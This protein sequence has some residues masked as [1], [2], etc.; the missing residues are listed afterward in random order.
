MTSRL[1][2]ILTPLE[3]KNFCETG[4]LDGD[5]VSSDDDEEEELVCGDTN[6]S[7]N[8]R[9]WA[10]MVAMVQERVIEQVE[11]TPRKV[12]SAPIMGFSRARDDERKA[13]LAGTSGPI[14]RMES[15]PAYRLSRL[16]MGMLRGCDVV[17]EHQE[18]YCYLKVIRTEEHLKVATKLGGWPSLISLLSLPSE[19]FVDGDAMAA[20]TCTVRGQ[21]V[22]VGAVNSGATVGVDFV[23]LLAGL[24]GDDVPEWVREV[25]IG[26]ETRPESSI[27]TMGHL[28]GGLGVEWHYSNGILVGSSYGVVFR[29]TYRERV[30][31]SLGAKPSLSQVFAFP[32]NFYKSDLVDLGFTLRHG[33]IVFLP[34][35]DGVRVFVLMRLLLSELNDLKMYPVLRMVKSAV[36][37][38]SSTGLVPGNVVAEVPNIPDMMSVQRMGRVVE[39]VLSGLVVFE[40]SV[41]RR[42]LQSQVVALTEMGLVLGDC[43]FPAVWNELSK[44]AR[45]DIDGF[46]GIIHRAYEVYAG[47]FKSWVAGVVGGPVDNLLNVYGL[48]A[49]YI[50]RILYSL[51][52]FVGVGAM[53]LLRIEDKGFVVQVAEYE[54]YVPVLS[55]WLETGRV[56][57]ERLCMRCG[58]EHFVLAVCGN[59]VCVTEASQPLAWD[60]G[61]H[62]RLESSLWQVLYSF[63]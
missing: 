61:V 13:R 46:D 27:V 20:L 58:L 11:S 32:P 37:D 31:S 38:V 30:T 62:V 12:V 48:R 7:Y 57:T 9:W 22:H 17:N 24:R 28:V 59:V 29:D 39:G 4:S 3:Y 54:V 6:V 15:D 1:R 21:A 63:D 43:A 44:A 35:G 51:L 55:P 45:G 36:I 2:E 52:K 47:S 42:T 34:R 40:K 33:S 18:G 25:V 26:R 41:V 23:S 53:H 10:D 8:A 49:S 5:G 14:Y 56:S 19:L 60:V 16:G 50:V